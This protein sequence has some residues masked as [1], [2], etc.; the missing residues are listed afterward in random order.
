MRSSRSHERSAS[1][2]GILS[3]RAERDSR[4]GLKIRTPFHFARSATRVKIRIP[5]RGT[6]LLRS[7]LSFLLAPLALAALLSCSAPAAETRETVEF[8]GLGREGEVVAQMIPEFEKRNPGI[9]VIVQQIPWTAAHEKFLTAWVGESA[10]DV[11]QM[12]NT[13]IPEMVA[14]HAVDDLTAFAAGSKSIDERDYFPGIWATNVV[15]GTLYGVPWYVDTRV[16]FYR[17]DILASVGY[18][19]PPQ[20]WDE[21]VDA[22]TRITKEKKAK[23]GILLP[24]NEWEPLVCL[25]LTDHSTLLNGGGTAGAFEQPPFRDAFTFYISLFRRGLAPKVNNLQVANLYQQ[26]ARGDFAMYITG[27]WNVGE[28]RRRLPPSMNGKWATAPLPARNAASQT[29]ISMAGGSSLVLFRSSHHTAAARK[30][31]E[32][33]SEPAQQI[34]FYELT[35]DLPARRSAWRSPSLA[36]DPHF[37]AFR[38]QLER[39]EPLPKVPEWEQ[40]ATQIYQHGEATVRGATTIDQ[41]LADLDRKS[42]EIL[43]KRRWVLAHEGR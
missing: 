30:L 20:T 33:L 29:G 35:G 5:R 36:G 18:T 34:R 19:R 11:A 1:A 15:D 4:G 42:G 23:F 43:A 7:I 12:G 40:I 21:W 6:R 39:V 14:L 26:F 27:P 2:N 41:S 8:W 13:W 22:M 9:H 28:F 32:F 10:P 17:S 25:A 3:I 31:I 24:T 16:L 37:P 38:I